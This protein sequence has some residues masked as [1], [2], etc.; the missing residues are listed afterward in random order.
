MKLLICGLL[1]CA[2]F[3]VLSACLQTAPRESFSV[4]WNYDTSGYLEVCGCSA[5]Q[6]GGLPRRATKLEELESGGPV[7]K[8][9][10]AHFF[11]EA[12]T[13]QMMKGEAIVKALKQ[14]DYD[15]LVLGVREAQQGA[16][17]LDRLAA[18]TDIPFVSAN[19]YSN[20]APYTDQSLRIAIAGNDV[21]LT[22]VSQP[23]FATFELPAGMSIEDPQLALDSV[24]ADL[25]GADCTII[26][27]EGDPLWLA[28]MKNR[29][30]GRAALFLTGNR[31]TLAASLDFE[32]NPPAINNWKLGRYL[33]FVSF[34]PLEDGGYALSG[35]NIPL[36]EEL[37]D[38]ARI[39]AVLDEFKGG[40]KDVFAEIMPFDDDSIYFPPEYCAACH[41]SQYDS[42]VAS[43]HAKARQTLE[44]DNQLYNLDCISCH[45][46]YDPDENELMP[47]NCI[48][49]HSNIDDLHV[50]AAMDDPSSIVAPD[51]PVTSYDYAF[52]VRCHDELNSTPFRDHWPQYVN[53]IFHG[54][55]MTRAEEAAALLGLDIT[56]DP[57]G[58]GMAAGDG[59]G[60]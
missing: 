56:A 14:M 32:N 46:I 9:E 19:V 44:D 31:D 23:E 22:A 36:D 39:T 57:P 45:I 6:L 58:H 55:D 54:G 29:Y 13:F 24:L 42:Y 26:C 50:Y 52:C 4:A 27:L 37:V 60:H 7:L 28:D 48:T 38:S 15:A 47:M 21:A 43:G 12:G 17:E 2:L 53:R 51:P 1:L 11:E 34:D 33:G 59:A 16:S 25:V 5:H 8:I 10:G 30:A 40:L 18:L 49:C 20:G 41:Q 3:G 35:L